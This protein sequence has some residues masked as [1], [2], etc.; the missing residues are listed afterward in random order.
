LLAE[1]DLLNWIFPG[2]RVGKIVPLGHLELKCRDGIAGFIVAAINHAAIIDRGAIGL[3]DWRIL[4]ARR[5]DFWLRSPP[6]VGSTP[7][8]S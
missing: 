5:L 1:L 3:M 2:G 7:G 8:K 4:G 6:A